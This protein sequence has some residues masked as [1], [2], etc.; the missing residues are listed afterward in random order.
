MAKNI[1][2]ELNKCKNNIFK[3]VLI[4]FVDHIN[5]FFCSIILFFTLIKTKL[6]D[7]P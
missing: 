5:M 4:F 1:I 6:N 3:N 2:L 7:I